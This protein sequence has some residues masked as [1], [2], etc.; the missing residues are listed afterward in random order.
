[1][2]SSYSQAARAFNQAIQLNAIPLQW[3]GFNDEM[4]LFI[5]SDWAK[6]RG[7][8]ALISATYLPW[9]IELWTKKK[10]METHAKLQAWGLIFFVQEE[11][12]AFLDG[13]EIAHS[14][15]Y[16]ESIQGW[17]DM[18]ATLSCS[19]KTAQNMDD[20]TGNQYVTRPGKSKGRGTQA[21]ST[22]RKLAKMKDEFNKIKK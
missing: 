11:L 3:I 18:A 1:M 6:E 21:F 8:Q 7:I 4:C 13:H 15:G 17:K 22:K 19:I 10:V 16:D 12:I 9:P 14:L 5:P 20:A 2:L